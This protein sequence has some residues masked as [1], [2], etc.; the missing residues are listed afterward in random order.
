M[1]VL[2]V[3]VSALPRR[4]RLARINHGWSF[5]AI[6]ADKP[7]SSLIL[8]R[9]GR[10]RRGLFGQPPIPCFGQVAPLHHLLADASV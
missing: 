1:F 8:A 10:G 3:S 2:G 6:A 5:S 4:R 9:I 7:E